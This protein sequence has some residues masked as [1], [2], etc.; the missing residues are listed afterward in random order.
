MGKGYYIDAG[1]DFSICPGCG[2]KVLRGAMRC[3]RC[4]QPLITLQ[5]QLDRIEKLKRI[6]KGRGAGGLVVFVLLLLASGLAYHFF[7][8]SIL[9]FVRGVL[10]R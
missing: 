2:Q 8:G 9:A 3:M 6:K 4:G 10:G 1:A 7:S 5:E